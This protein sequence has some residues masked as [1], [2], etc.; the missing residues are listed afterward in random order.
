MS[1]K[2]NVLDDYKALFGHD[3]DKNPSGIGLL[4]DGTAVEKPSGCDYSSF[5]ISG[6]G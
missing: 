3:L 4:T 2:V 1:H 6:E 5:A